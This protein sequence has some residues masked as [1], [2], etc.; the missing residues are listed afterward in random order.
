MGDVK[1]KKILKGEYLN[2]IKCGIWEEY[3]YEK[4]IDD[5]QMWNFINVLKFKFE[6]EFFKEKKNGKGKEQYYFTNILFEGEYLNGKKWQGKEYDKDGKI[7]YE[8]I[9]GNGKVREYYNDGTL[10][11]EGEYL[12][13]FKTGKGK[14]W[15]RHSKLLFNGEYLNGQRWNG[16][17]K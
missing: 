9:Q 13:G 7:I 2:G 3:Y 12:N 15:D 11:F 16:I 4:V 1:T 5:Y 17:Y 6:G 14:E 8:L 10:K